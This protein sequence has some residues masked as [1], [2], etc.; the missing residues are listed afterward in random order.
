MA[1]EKRPKVS[2][3]QKVQEAVL[4]WI[5]DNYNRLYHD[6]DMKNSKEDKKEAWKELTKY[7]N[8]LL[9]EE[10][11]GSAK[12]KDSRKKTILLFHDLPQE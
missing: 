11:K 3:S 6:L 2:F 7:A 4:L 10:K 5:K 9:E 1:S 8:D 12:V